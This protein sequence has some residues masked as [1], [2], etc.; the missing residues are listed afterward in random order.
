MEGVTTADPND[1]TGLDPLGDRVMKN[2]PPISRWPLP[3]DKLWHVPRKNLF[4]A[5]MQYQLLGTNYPIVH[6]DYIIILFLA[7]KL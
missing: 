5:F 4:M 3:R 1:P 7:H 2:V 6:T